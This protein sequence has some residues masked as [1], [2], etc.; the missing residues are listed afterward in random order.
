[1]DET[2]AAVADYAV[3]GA[4]F[5]GKHIAQNTPFKKVFAVGVSG[6][7]KHHEI[8]PL[9][10][11]DRES[12]IELEDLESFISFSPEN[13]DCYYV[14][15]VLGEETSYEK[16]SEQILK[17]ARELHEHLR[18]YG[19][20]SDQN[21]PLVVASILLALDESDKNAFS[22]EALVGDDNPGQRD[23][24][25]ILNAIKSRLTRSR[26]APQEKKD[27]LILQ[28][29]FI[30]DEET[31]N[32]VNQDLGMTP[33][34]YFTRFLN[35]RVFKSIKYQDSSEDIIG[36]FY[37]EFVSYSGGDGQTLGIV[38]TPRHICDLMC[39]LVDVR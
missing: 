29:S 28:F 35:D 7:E 33:L 3:N 10:V 30:A 9:W 17:D 5:Y 36:R 37:G 2:W 12:Y 34:K 16:T 26:V 24:D 31:L 20:L 38:L 13:I 11:N 21:K 39:D 25:K 4:Y 1:M 6:D 8:T 19:S 32:E 27:K 15:N 18:T 23:G 22:V 14:R